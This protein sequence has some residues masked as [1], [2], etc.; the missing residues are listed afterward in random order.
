MDGR[1]DEGCPRWCAGEHDE[2]VAAAERLHRSAASSVPVVL[3]AR[4]D[5]AAGAT[6]HVSL[7][8]P[9]ESGEDRLRLEADGLGEVDLDLSSG[10][11]LAG[12]VLRLLGA[13]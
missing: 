7:C 13:S 10:S 3:W 2:L 4:G 6:V 5:G 9:G 1:N 8:R 12:A 11:R